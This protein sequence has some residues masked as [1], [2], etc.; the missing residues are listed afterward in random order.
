[1]QNNIGLFSPEWGSHACGCKAVTLCGWG[2]AT[3]AD[4]KWRLIRESEEVQL[5]SG[6]SR[7]ARGLVFSLFFLFICANG[8][9]SPSGAIWNFWWSLLRRGTTS[10]RTKCSDPPPM[11]GIFW[12]M[13]VVWNTWRPGNKEKTWSH[14][15]LHQ[16]VRRCF[17]QTPP[18]CDAATCRFGTRTFLSQELFYK[19][20]NATLWWEVISMKDIF[21]NVGVVWKP[22]YIVVAYLALYTD[23]A[24]SGILAV[25]QDAWPHPG[26]ILFRLSDKKLLTCLRQHVGHSM[27]NISTF[28]PNYD[29]SMGSLL[30]KH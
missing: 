10:K 22:N 29:R 8:G 21:Y 27:E 1:M 24:C 9:G 11:S 16:F 14:L 2:C 20:M 6:T 17:L 28:L 18:F 12:R 23:W 25:F 5:D 15:F 13:V 3:E 7:S 26:S 4:H 19:I 30:Y